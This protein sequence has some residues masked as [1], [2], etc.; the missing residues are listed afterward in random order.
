[1]PYNDTDDTSKPLTLSDDSFTIDLRRM[2]R[3]NDLALLRD[4]PLKNLLPRNPL[5]L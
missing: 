4:Q 1:M 2:R 3:Q 5:H